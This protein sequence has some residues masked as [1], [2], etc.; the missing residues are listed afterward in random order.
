MLDV[1]STPALPMS[2]QLAVPV[3]PPKTPTQPGAR[4]NWYTPQN[5]ALIA[6]PHRPGS[7]SET[8]LAADK[9]PSSTD[10]LNG[11]Y[12]RP[13]SETSQLKDY[14][15]TEAQANPQVPAAMHLQAPTSRAYEN[16]PPSDG[17]RY[18]SV[19]PPSSAVAADYSGHSYSDASQ[20]RSNGQ[21]LCPAYSSVSPGISQLR[22]SA[23]R[24]GTHVQAIS[25]PLA[26]VLPARPTSIPALPLPLPPAAAATGV[27][28]VAI[29]AVR[30]AHSDT[31]ARGSNSTPSHIISALEDTRSIYEL[32][33]G[34]LENVVARVIRED[35]FASLVR[36]YAR[37]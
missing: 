26:E 17:L 20:P 2:S 18:S 9:I 37:R 3:M 27:P 16:L 33:R 12:M 22:D 21:H 30:S 25:D 29:P 6:T 7:S 23:C 8:T 35:G 4:Q 24:S 32:S 34:E 28:D 1:N 36:A 14:Y 5:Y 19:G 31:S 15:F 13:H 11:A 10:C